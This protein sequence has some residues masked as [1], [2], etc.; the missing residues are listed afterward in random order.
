M[1]LAFE[2]KRSHKGQNQVTLW[3]KKKFLCSANLFIYRAVHVMTCFCRLTLLVVWSG[4]RGLGNLFTAVVNHVAPSWRRGGDMI[5]HSRGQ[6]AGDLETCSRLWWIMSPRA[7]G[8]VATC[9]TTAM[10]WRQ[11]P[12]PLPP[13]RTTNL[14]YCKVLPFQSTF[15]KF[16]LLL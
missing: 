13:D 2:I 8:E 10:R 4:G 6:V 3:S 11:F 7:E 9:F 14:L 5:C 16:F 12:S 1:K 15:S